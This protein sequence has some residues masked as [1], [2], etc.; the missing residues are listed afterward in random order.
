MRRID[1][2]IN[3]PN[4]GERENTLGQSENLFGDLKECLNERNGQLNRI[5]LSFLLLL[6]L[7]RRALCKC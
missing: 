4:S 7:Q 5:F 2:I 1:A 6:L 3:I